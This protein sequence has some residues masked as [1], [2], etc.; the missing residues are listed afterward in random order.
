L[1]AN[2]PTSPTA[3][4]HD[5]PCPYNPAADARNGFGSE[6]PSPISL[7]QL[8]VRIQATLDGFARAHTNL[9]GFDLPDPIAMAVA[10]DPQTATLTRRLYV[11]VETAGQLTR[12][13]TVIDHLRLTNREPNAD[14]VLEASRER[15]DSLLKLTLAAD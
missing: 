11:D 2:S 10:I 4:S 3:R 6:V 15:F 7:G 13:Q 8:S 1:T 14:V 5:D 12:G 9:P